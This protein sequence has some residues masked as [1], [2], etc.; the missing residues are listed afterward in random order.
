MDGVHE[1]KYL[2]YLFV[3][4][5]FPELIPFPNVQDLLTSCSLMPDPAEAKKCRERMTDAKVDRLR[6]EG[7]EEICVAE[8]MCG[9]K[10]FGKKMEEEGKEEERLKEKRRREEEKLRAEG[11][12]QIPE[13]E[14][15]EKGEGKKEEDKDTICKVRKEEEE[16]KKKEGGG[17]KEQHTHRQMR[18]E[19]GGK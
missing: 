15:E 1:L 7:A 4:C 18:R 16:E 14:K 19:G 6:K 11:K 2:K 10:E 17:E 5:H 12:E 8:G 3:A 13:V 9:R